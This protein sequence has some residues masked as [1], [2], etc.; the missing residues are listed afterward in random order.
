MGFYKRQA[1]DVVGAEILLTIEGFAGLLIL[2][3]F[4]AKR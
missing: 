2:Q 1:S 4:R 3:N